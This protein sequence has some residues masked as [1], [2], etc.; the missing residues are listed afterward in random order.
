MPKYYAKKKDKKTIHSDYLI[1]VTEYKGEEVIV[2][3]KPGKALYIQVGERRFKFPPEF[4]YNLHS[5]TDIIQKIDHLASKPK[6]KYYVP[7]GIGYYTHLAKT[8]EPPVSK[9]EAVIATTKESFYATKAKAKLKAAA[10]VK[11]I[12]ISMEDLAKIL[13]KEKK[14]AD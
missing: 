1:C 7:F 4:E 8:P 11:E 6:Q 13:I 10:F 2:W 12:T 14:H 5:Y 3:K 9:K